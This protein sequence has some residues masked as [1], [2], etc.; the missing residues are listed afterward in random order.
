VFAVYSWN[1]FGWS[2]SLLVGNNTPL[3]LLFVAGFI[4]AQLAN[5]SVAAGALLGIAIATKLWPATLLVPLARERSWRTI[6]WAVGVAATT[7]AVLLLWLGGPTVISPLLRALALR[8]EIGPNQPVVGITWLRER[9]DWWPE[10]GGY[11]VCA[12]VLLI[13][14]KGLT[15]YGLAV[16]AGMAAIP[17]L[18]RHYYPTIFFSIV[19]TI[20]GLIDGWHERAGSDGAIPSPD[21]PSA[22]GDTRL[23]DAGRVRYQAALRPD[24]GVPNRPDSAA[25]QGST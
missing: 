21:A 11:A 18:W 6:A 13:P 2:R 14:A 10:W 9:T 7:T 17:N 25:A 4:A 15:G 19:I 22:D 5:R 3:L 20:R 1:A 12:L 16:S 23:A 8:D 24:G